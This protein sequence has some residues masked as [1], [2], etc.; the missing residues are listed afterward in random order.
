MHGSHFPMQSSFSWTDV[1][2]DTIATDT[3][4]RIQLY[5]FG[6]IFRSI[7]IHHTYPGHC[8]S[9]FSVSFK[10]QFIFLNSYHFRKLSLS[11]PVLQLQG[12]DVWHWCGKHRTAGPHRKSLKLLPGSLCCPTAPLMWHKHSWRRPRT[13]GDAAE[14]EWHQPHPQ[15]LFKQPTVWSTLN[16]YALKRYLCFPGT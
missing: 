1:N 4:I 3:N 16:K 9:L 2:I 5:S 6:K 13:W 11:I 14:D 10:R 12:P 7:C 15:L 8:F